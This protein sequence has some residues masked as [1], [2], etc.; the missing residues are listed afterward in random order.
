ML[1]PILT[2]FLGVFLAPIVRPLLRPFFVELVR[3]TL[4]TAD[5]VRRLSAEVR[6]NVEDAAAEA[7]AQHAARAEATP[8]PPAAPQ[9]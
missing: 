4:M 3:A 5:E 1:I 9:V 7:R 2:F 8:P 6:E